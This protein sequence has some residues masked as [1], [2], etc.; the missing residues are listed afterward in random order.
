M[1][2]HVRKRGKKWSAVV[3]LGNDDGAKK[4]KWYGGFDTKKEAETFLASKVVEVNN[5]TFINKDCTFGEFIENW[6][7]YKEKRIRPGSYVA[8]TKALNRIPDSI[9]KL[10]LEKLSPQH[11][12]HLY[13]ELEN[14]GLSSRTTKHLHVIINGI[15]KQ[16]VRWEFVN[17]NVAS[18]VDSPTFEQRSLRVWNIDELQ[19]FIH[20]A[21]KD[22][23]Y[24]LFMLAISTG[25]RRGELLGLRWCDVDLNRCRLQI[26]QAVTYVDSKPLVGP[27]KTPSSQRSITF[28][29]SIG[30]LLKRHKNAQDRLKRDFGFPINSTDYVFP[31]NDHLDMPIH[32]STLSYHFKDVCLSANVPRIRFHDL[33]HTHATLL[34]QQGVNLKV[35]QDR[36]GHSKIN[37][38]LDIYSHVLP[39]MQRQASD[40]IAAILEK[41]NE[42]DA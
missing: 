18:L 41:D 32:S 34:L 27:P 42:P 15:L 36:L 5:G 1:R 21:E 20:H 9:R 17:K 11:L 7:T 35:I 38:T 4:Y 29:E 33:R 26:V 6:L 25:M 3:Y 13:N 24:A 16:A 40:E 8:Y 22:D 31:R 10:R 23:Y 12:Q 19:R 14:D 30:Y 28:P 39:D 2:G 37:V